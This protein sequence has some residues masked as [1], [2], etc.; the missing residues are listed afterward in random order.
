MPFDLLPIPVIGG[1]DRRQRSVS[2]NER[3]GSHVAIFGWQSA[4]GST[5]TANGKGFVGLA[6]G[7]GTLTTCVASVITASNNTLDS[8]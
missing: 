6:F 2:V 4:E 5:I 8:L 1:S 3:L 7:Q